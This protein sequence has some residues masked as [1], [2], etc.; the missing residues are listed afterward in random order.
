MLPRPSLPLPALV[1]LALS[2]VALSAAIHVRDGLF[3]PVAFEWLTLSLL[4]AIAAFVFL[5]PRGNAISSWRSFF[6]T[7]ITINRLRLLLF[8]GLLFELFQLLTSRPGSDYAATHGVSPTTL[9]RA[10]LYLVAA[11]TPLLL[12]PKTARAGLFVLVGLFVVMGISWLRSNPQP[13]MDV[14]WAQQS[15]LSE[16]VQGRSPFASTYPDIYNQPEGGLVHNGRVLAGFPYPPVTFWLDLPGYLIARDY[17]YANLGAVALSAI[18]I[19]LA[20][21]RQRG[22]SVAP[23]AAALFLFTP[24]V[25]FILESGWTEPSV[26]LPLALAL[27]CAM[28]FPHLLGI[29]LG[30][31][32]AS[33]QYM[34]FA[35]PLSLL[36]IPKPLVVKPT[37]RLFGLA[38]LAALL[39]SLPL[40]VWNVPA[41]LRSNLLLATGAG[42]R[43][44]AQLPGALSRSDRESAADVD[45]EPVGLCPCHCRHGHCPLACAAQRGRVLGRPGAGVHGLLRLREI[46]LL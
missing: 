18:C 6:T 2:A 17:R 7:R 42:L 1:L 20:A 45:R 13:F 29:P 30:L 11:L 5:S 19:A 39:T 27:V 26:I 23:L 28:R 44:C 16:F 24:R 40:I 22:A 41:F 8:I 3:Q 33:K 14:W 32:W 25:F 21:P 15:G 46:R 34:L 9:F 37:I 35:I 38:L 43:R 31:F 4:A 10:S 36:L 12:F